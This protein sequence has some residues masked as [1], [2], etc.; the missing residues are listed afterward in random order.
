[1]DFSK[2]TKEEISKID[3]QTLTDD[4]IKRLRELSLRYSATEQAIKLAINSIYGAFANEYFHFYNMDIA[5]TVTLQGQDAIKYTEKMTEKYFSEFYHKDK[6]LHE[7]LGIDATKNI[8]P[9]K[10]PVWKYTD[11]DSIPGDSIIDTNEGRLKIIDLYNISLEKNGPGDSTR[12]GHESTTTDLLVR[13]LVNGKAKYSKVKRL[14]R[15]KV[16]KQKWKLESFSGRSIQM[17]EDHSAVIFRDNQKI[18]IKPEEIVYGD[19]MVILRED[20]SV[21]F[22]EVKNVE[23]SGYFVDDWVFDIEMIP[24]DDDS[25][26]T[27]TFFANDILV[28]NSGYLVFEECMEAVDWKGT[29]KDFIL[30]INEHRLNAYYEKVL[31]DYAKFNNT[32][33]FLSFE[34]ETI[35]D[36]A[37]WVAKKK[38]VQNITWKDGKHFEPLE[39]IKTTGLEIIQ[40]STPVFCREKLIESVKFIFSKGKLTIDN[41]SELISLIKEIKQEF[42]LSNIEKISMSR[43]I[44][45]YRKYVLDDVE[46]MSLNKGCP[47]HVRAAAYHN[48]LLNQNKLKNKYE[49][50]GAGDKIKYYHCDDQF[51]NIFAF[52]PGNYP[53]EFAPK[54]NLEL[55]FKMSILDPLNRII[56]PTGLPPLNPSL[57]YTPGGLF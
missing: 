5:E 33:N 37:I 12:E 36:N 32:E 48:Y 24:E 21:V 4:D 38:Y 10:R 50:I 39:Y 14:I 11:T 45:N 15:H 57:A 13:N 34:L 25:S 49:L 56:I 19:L 1:M 9:I 8:K 28:H 26:D 7:K 6:K 30:K 52:K 53:I 31:S 35:A 42:K 2:L 17:T 47:I 16:T 43:G 27:H 51:C 3:P 54:I 46:E 29:V 44:S 23:P 20:E 22:E 18:A 41:M 55:Q 40:S